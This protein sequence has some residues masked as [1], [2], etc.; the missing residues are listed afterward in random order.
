[1]IKLKVSKALTRD[2]ATDMIITEVWAENIPKHQARLVI[3]SALE[4][5]ALGELEKIEETITEV[6]EEAKKP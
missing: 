3:M 4:K 2:E 1:M 6:F 5:Y